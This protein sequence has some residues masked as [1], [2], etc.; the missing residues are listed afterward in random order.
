MKKKKIILI[1]IAAIVVVAAVAAVIVCSKLPHALNYPIDEIE[2]SKAQNVSVVSS[3]NDEVVIQKNDGGNF[4]IVMFTDMH[5][6]GNNETGYKTIERMVDTVQKEQ[7]D[8]VLLG[9]DNVTGGMTEKRAHQLGEI[10]EKLGVYWGGVL[11]NHEGDNNWSISRT[12]MMDVFMSYDHCIMQKGLGIIDGDCNYVIKLLNKKGKLIEAIFCLDTFDEI[13]DE[14]RET[15]E[16]IDGKKY[17]GAHANQVEWYKQKAE[18]MKKELK[19]KKSIMLIHI[20]LPAYDKAYSDGKILYGEKNEDFCS[21][22]YENGLFEAIKECGVTRA[23][24][25]GHDHVNNIGM[26]YEGIV[27]SYIEQSGYGS[28]GMK[29]KG[30]PE[31]EWL[32]G[33]TVLEFGKDGNFSHSQNK[34]AEIYGD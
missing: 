19:G 32:Q 6:D 30:A 20:P 16:I 9:G 34:Y 12:K 14:Q 10:F 13:S 24:F 33:Y 23:V 18:G 15:L 17:D 8:L 5:L 22:A 11:G 25:C 31:S 29:K 1:I 2:P 21:T 28:Y 4:R 3:D 27:L 7:P 26:E